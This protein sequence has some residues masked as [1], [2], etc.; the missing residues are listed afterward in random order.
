[1]KQ[2]LIVAHRGASL[3]AR[4][5]TLTAFEK[6]IELGVDM[7]EFDIRR[8]RDGV[9]VVY[10]DFT[11]A[12]LP[13]SQLTYRVANELAGSKNYAIPM[14]VD[15]LELTQGRVCL[16]VELK[17]AG[18]EGAVADLLAEYFSPADFV[19]TSFKDQVVK[20]MKQCFPQAQV[21]LL[22]GAGWPLI[23]SYQDL[24]PERRLAKCRADLVAAHYSLLQYDFLN[25]MRQAGLPVYIW[26][27]DDTVLLQRL[28]HDPL[29]DAV[30]TN[31]PELAMAVM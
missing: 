21:G 19:V 9:M 12:G 11:I 14:L 27:V 10:H 2:S 22:L 8:T 25:R 15:V 16:D 18:Y 6:A 17:E 28:L 26:T 5:N 4:E 20:T 7:I 3:L 29:V 23:F 13:L 1:M 31:D 24:F 30:I